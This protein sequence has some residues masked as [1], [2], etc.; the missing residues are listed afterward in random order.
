MRAYWTDLK[1]RLVQ[2]VAEGPPMLCTPLAALTS[3]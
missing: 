2:A 3:P 1:E